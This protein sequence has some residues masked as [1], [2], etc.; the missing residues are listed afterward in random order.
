M[1]LIPGWLA[2]PPSKCYKKWQK[3][4][5][6]WTS[7]R[8]ARRPS[9]AENSCMESVSCPPLS[10]VPLPWNPTRP[11]RVFSWSASP[12]HNWCHREGRCSQEVLFTKE[13]VPA[14]LTTSWERGGGLLLP[15]GSPSYPAAPPRAA[16][17]GEAPRWALEPGARCSSLCCGNS[18]DQGIGSAPRA[19]LHQGPSQSYTPAETLTPA[20]RCPLSP[21]Q[22]AARIPQLSPQDGAPRG[23]QN[24][25]RSVFPAQQEKASSVLVNPL[26]HPLPSK[27]ESKSVVPFFLFSLFQSQPWLAWFYFFFPLH[28]NLAPSWSIRGK[29][30]GTGEFHPG[31]CISDI[32][33]WAGA[34]DSWV[35]PWTQPDALAPGRPFSS[36][37]VPSSLI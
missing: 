30:V 24:Q 20:S 9:H 33:A 17:K 37:W 34:H 5:S 10:R 15:M 36:G 2:L 12:P 21:S 31:P 13:R 29:W 32:P 6:P 19:G 26:S 14:G 7:D 3:C 8:P 28:L 4:F 22:P 23:L 18:L 35:C 1:L 16:G 25:S 27:N 11:P